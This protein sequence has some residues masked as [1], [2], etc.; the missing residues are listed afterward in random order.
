M[1]DLKE[2]NYKELK[3]INGGS[4][5]PGVYSEPGNDGCEPDNPLKDILG[6]LNP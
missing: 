6:N 4:T 2:I 1:K 5:S 3:A